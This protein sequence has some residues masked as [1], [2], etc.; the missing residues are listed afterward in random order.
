MHRVATKVAQEVS[1]LLQ[2]GDLHT[3][4]RQ[5][6]AQNHPGRAAADDRAR[7]CLAH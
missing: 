5:Q 6:Q 1:V 2:Q 7:G 3:C 4:P